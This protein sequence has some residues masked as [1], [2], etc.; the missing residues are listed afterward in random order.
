MSELTLTDQNFEKE[1][2][3]S[4]KVVLVDFWSP[5]CPPCL[6]L[7]PI[8]EEIAEDFKDKVNV[9]KLNVFENPK[10][11]EKYKIV[12]IPTIIVFK[13]GEIKEREIGLKSK[14]VI[15]DKLNSLL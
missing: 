10:T 1:V 5:T 11:A 13:D 15:A 8:I 14:Q 9:G 4:K 7:A 3:K 2:L 6:I 12:S